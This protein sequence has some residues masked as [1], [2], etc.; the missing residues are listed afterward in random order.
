MSFLKQK[1]AKVLELKK[2]R[3]LAR[4]RHLHEDPSSTPLVDNNPRQLRN[5]AREK[6][7]LTYEDNN[8]EFS[9][10]DDSMNR[11]A[12]GN[13]VMKNYARAMVRFSLSALADPYLERMKEKYAMESEDFKKTLRGHKAKVNCIK[14]LRDILLVSEQ[15]SEETRTFKKMF[16]ELCVIFMKFFSVNWIYHGKMLERTKYIKYRGKMLRRVQ[17]PEYFTY[18][19]S[20]VDKKTKK[21]DSFSKKSPS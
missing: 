8:N 1:I 12:R 15:D 9:D 16:Q 7:R 3:R 18:L 17:N 10:S 6:I 14:H 2:T 11:R 5:E 20:F 4:L 21:K 13:N 19:E